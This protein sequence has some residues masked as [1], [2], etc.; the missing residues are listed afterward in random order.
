ML[1]LPTP[2]KTVAQVHAPQY[3]STVR[4]SVIITTFN[5]PEQLERVLW[6]YAAQTHKDFEV[7]VAD[8]GSTPATTEVIDR[9]ASSAGLDVIHVWHEHRGFR[10]TEILNRAIVA[11]TSEYLIFSDGDC[12]PRND[13]VAT[14]ASLA[15]PGYFLSGGYLKLP[16][17]VSSQITVSAIRSGNATDPSWLRARGWKP[18]KRALRL[19]R[20]KTMA[21]ILDL[22]TPTRRTGMAITL[23][24]GKVRSSKPN[25]STWTWG[26][27]GSTGPRRAAHGMRD[28]A[29]KAGASSDTLPAPASRA[30]L[31]RSAQVEAQP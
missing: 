19:L 8:D 26:M 20:N 16:Q 6:G 28:S 27:A 18:G 13:F 1:P 3:V 23:R 5:Q 15:E 9:V 22:V 11:T 12:I 25:G 24:R 7:V 10:K 14:H 31:R 21:S 29:R 4:V 17:D 2:T 30:A